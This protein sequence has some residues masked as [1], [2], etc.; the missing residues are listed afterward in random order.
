[1]PNSAITTNTLKT[2]TVRLAERSNLSRI[3]NRRQITANKR[4]KSEEWY[5]CWYLL[6]TSKCDKTTLNIILHSKCWLLLRKWKT[7]HNNMQNITKYFHTKN[8]KRIIIF[9]VKIMKSFLLP[10]PFFRVHLSP[11]LHSQLIRVVSIFYLLHI[12][13]CRILKANT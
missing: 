4:M 10:S 8:L 9:I 3:L 1:M 7:M 13:S 2:T 12:P 11:F 5:N 6:I